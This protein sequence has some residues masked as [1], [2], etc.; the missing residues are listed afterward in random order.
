MI[1]LF[2]MFVCI[3]SWGTVHIS[4]P[5]LGRGLVIK[6]LWAAEGPGWGTWLHPSAWKYMR[7]L[8]MCKLYSYGS[9]PAL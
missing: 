5:M 9:I 3:R 7:I 4:Y 2:E 8:L 6:W 1:T